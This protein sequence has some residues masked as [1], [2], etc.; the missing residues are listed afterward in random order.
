MKKFLYR[1]TSLV[2]LLIIYSCATFL[3][4][5]R[6]EEKFADIPRAEREFRAAWVATVANI[7]WP[8]EPGLSTEEQKAEAIA[9]LDTAQNLNLNAIIFQVRP[10]CDALYNSNIEPWSYYLTGEQGKAP[11]PYYDPLTFWVD[12]AH[13]RGMELHAWFN[14][15]R[16]HHPIGGKITEHSIINKKP[17]LAKKLS[18]GFVW[19][20]PAMKETQKHSMDVILDVVKRYDIDGVHIDDYFYPYPSYNDGEDFPDDDSWKEYQKAKGKL[21]RGDWRRKAVNDFVRDLY[22]NMKAEKRHV[23]FGISPFGIWRPNHPKSIKGF[24]QYEKLYADARLWLQKGWV[25]YFTPQLYW[26]INKIPQSYPVLL[27]WWDRQNIKHRNLW[28]GLFTSKVVDS[29]W[30]DENIN[31]I[32]V[33]RG[34]VHHNPGHV[35]FSMKAFLRNDSLGFNN[36]LTSSVYKKQALVPTSPWLDNKA[37]K[38]PLS[39]SLQVDS[40]DTKIN[41]EIE[42]T[43]DVFVSAVYYKYGKFW[44]HKIITDNT[45]S[46]PSYFTQISKE[47]TTD[48]ALTKV[49]ITNVDRCGNES[50]PIIGE[51]V[52]K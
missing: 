47:D 7:D 38:A 41:W 19:L 11:E 34:I 40:T 9:I 12:E 26:T 1:F 4:L 43:D 51:I 3:P 52:I 30:I 49:A 24:D 14:P 31:Q 17:H 48:I 29:T 2:F 50:V 18:S 39:I 21:S 35:H 33:T 20:D 15:Y 28:P 46:I 42:N 6:I 27:G 37:P 8:S 25:D 23:K 36:A 10:H 45:L 44:N 32:M 5:K 16:A 22:V 13:K